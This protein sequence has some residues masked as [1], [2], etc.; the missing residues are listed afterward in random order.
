LDILERGRISL[1]FPVLAGEESLQALESHYKC[2]DLYHQVSSRF[3]FS[4]EKHGLDVEK[5]ICL[6]KIN[7][8]LTADIDKSGK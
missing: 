8:I 3:G 7:N 5:R 1:R 4:Y 6:D 2:L